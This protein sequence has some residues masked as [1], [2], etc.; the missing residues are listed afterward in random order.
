M[1]LQVWMPLIKDYENYG[2]SDLKFAN[3]RYIRFVI[4]A[5]K[6]GNDN[7][8]QLSRLE[9]IDAEGNLYKYPAGT[10]VSTSLTSYPANEPPASVIDGN[11]NTKFCTVWSA[12]G[13]LTIA[14]GGSETIDISRYS[15]FQW[16]TANDSEWRDPVSFEVQF[17][18]D[19]VNFVKGAVVTNAS[20]T[21][22]RYALAYT[23]N[24]FNASAGKI[25]SSCYYNP[26]Y[27]TGGLVSDT[28]INLGNKLSMC[29]WVKFSSLLS[30]SALGASMGGQ[31]RYPNCTGMGLTIKY[32]TSNTG[33]L[34]CNTGDGSN[35][36][37]NTYCGNTLLSA[38]TWYHVVFT[39][40]G[41]TIRFYVN[42][43]FDGSH[44]YTAQKNVEDYVFLGAWS[45]EHSTDN[46]TMYGH[47][48]L[49]GCMNDFRIYDHVLSKKEVKLLSQ[50][51][52]AHYQLKGMGATNYLKGAGKFLKDTPLV[53]NA[54]DVSHMNDSYVYHEWPPNDLFAIL[55]SAGTYTLS[56]ECDGI[57]SGHQT[58]GTTAS[59]RLFSFFLQNTSSGNHY[60]FTMSKG[61]D[62][63]WY[64]T[65]TDL[66]AGTYK[67]RTNLYAADNVN[68][69]V[70]FWNMKVTAGS[71]NPSDTWCPHADDELYN[72]LGLGLGKEPDCSGFGNDATKSGILEIISDSPRYG[73]C[74]RF[75]GS[76]YIACG[77]GAMV[78]DELTVSC[79]AYADN[80]ANAREI[81]SCAEGGGW[82]F[83]HN[84]SGQ[85]TMEV[86]RNGGYITGVYPTALANW[87][88]GWHHL[89]GVYDGYKA[90]IYVDGVKGTTSATTTTKY[91]ITYHA[92]N[93]LFIAAAAGASATTP[94]A[95]YFTGNISDV[96][97]YGTALSTSDV[98]DLYKNAASVSKDGELFAYDF[99]ENKRNTIDKN[100]I[101]ATEGFNDR[102]C[103]IYDM[104]T[105]V[106]ADGSS[107]ARI[108]YLDLTNDKTFFANAAEVAKCTNKH[109]RYSRMGDVDKFK[110][111]PSLPS[112]YTEIEYIQNTGVEYIDTGYAAPEGFITEAV[113]EYLSHN[114]GS[115]VG[116]HN[117]DAP[118]GRNGVG[119]NSTGWEIGTGDTCPASASLPILNKKY[120]VKGSTIKGNSYIEVDGTRVV[121]TAD[122]SS[123]CTQNVY[124]F[125]NQYTQYHNYTSSK[126]R[127]YYLRIY[128]PE[129]MLVR[130]FVPCKNASGTIGLYDLVGK[131]FYSN[132]GSGSFTAGTFVSKYE[133]ML[134]Y[135]ALSSTEYNRWT[136]TS[137]PNATS[138]TGYTPI[139][140]AWP[141]HSA[142]IRKHGSTSIYDCD[143]GD[144]W[145][146]PIGQTSI[147]EGGIPAANGNMQLQTE[148][149]VRTDKSAEATQTKIYDGTLV[150]SNF[151]EL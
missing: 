126:C 114:G 98:I 57:G 61:V 54:S 33:Y 5:I 21:S 101:V 137:S 107:W 16:Y 92:S 37:Y 53:R 90:E 113:V 7:Y 1:S 103:P 32:I 39:Y 83:W 70:K 4:N 12:G 48:K 17:S 74:Y 56:V 25:G 43:N 67:V 146:A 89:V 64:G 135:P 127:V 144:T 9:F 86:H 58:S 2:L 29:C 131:D 116:S 111:Q 110:S 97:I 68:Y 105:K 115:F 149:W 30:D 132:S 124:V 15:R 134:T 112:G 147:W 142:G 72:N 143:S 63:R 10:T 11:V 145:Y 44:S 24:C 13:H 148:L 38:G 118:Y 123:R 140:I 18:N 79:W 108:H 91:P 26:S 36:T 122:T 100:G 66:V 50:G 42:G 6:G 150:A 109:N 93:G 52:V 117:I 133:F 23:G 22:T 139:H 35:R 81:M 80:W 87:S 51:L 76:Q 77:R 3:F 95:S 8:A 104:S 34:S 20:I 65:Q 94:A 45:F 40:D 125:N 102:V 82:D 84:G 151:I 99:H 31:H 46:S 96:K 75:A 28:K 136:Q 62:G 120:F 85:M 119:I 128:S 78:T 88:A 60:H 55:P 129:G 71:Y 130:N 121:S 73:R 141:A 59:Q 106:L 14:L 47:Y 19:G 138:V 49:N 41:S 69:T 27:D